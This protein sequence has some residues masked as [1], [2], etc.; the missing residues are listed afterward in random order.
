MDM[1]NIAE[2]KKL[3]KNCVAEYLEKDGEGRYCLPQNKQ[4]P[5]YLL[6]AAGIGKTE[7]AAQAAR[8]CGVGFVSCSLN[9]YTRQNAAGMPA[10]VNREY[11]GKTYQV[12]EYTVSE[13]LELIYEKKR[14]GEQ[15]GILFVDEI[16]CISETMWPVMLQ[17]LQ[18]KT[19]GS[20]RIPEGWIIAA[21]GNPTEYNRSARDFDA[22]LCDRLRIIRIRPDVDVW[23]EYAD[24]LTIHPLILA[25]LKNYP[26]FFYVFEKKGKEQALVTPRGWED[27]SHA[28]SAAERL[29]HT[30]SMPLIRQ[31]LQYE[32]AVSSF[33][34]FY[35][36]QKSALSEREAE[37]IFQGQAALELSERI[38]REGL[39][40]RWTVTWMLRRSLESRASRIAAVLRK[41]ETGERQAV[42]EG[43]ERWQEELTHFL[44]WADETLGRGVEMENILSGLCRN[45]D[46]GYLL[47]VSG[48]ERYLC[49]CRE[50]NGQ[51]RRE[52]AALQKQM[53]QIE[54][55]K[56][57]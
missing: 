19:F 46:S 9:H 18:N 36:M 24:Q 12:T 15:E 39:A 30:V 13:I 35:E 16:N 31:F 21:A 14:A 25:F 50:M 42:S 44:E 52:R 4:R 40:V 1:V 8:E 27:L 29:G 49:L 20:Y 5:I 33:Y 6:G 22:V 38:R 2:A 57:K 54:V 45:R 47:A 55:R 51:G 43:L 10:I 3:L 37:M 32:Q 48:N 34:Q 26:A 11:G 17:F 56:E 23:M 41:Q 53:K 28:L 7:I